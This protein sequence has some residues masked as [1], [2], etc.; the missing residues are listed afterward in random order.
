MGAASAEDHA[1]LLKKVIKEGGKRGVEI[2]GASDMGG[3]QFFCTSVIEP[4]GDI[5]LLEECLNAMN[6]VCDPAEEE[7]KGGAGKVG[8]M[9]FSS[10]DDK[11]AIACD[12]PESKRDELKASDWMEA[13][14]ANFGGK[15]VKS[16]EGQ[17]FGEIAKDTDN[18]KFPL[19]MKDEGI[20]ISINHLKK[21]GL[22]PDGNDDSDDEY[23]F[24]DDDFPQ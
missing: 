9:V 6:V 21:L 2:E 24:G 3:L 15:M 20:Q 23:V 5:E 7:R 13:V 12:V 16:S 18:N 14:L 17:A 8:K 22:F 1:K 4:D 11:L 10:G 19:K